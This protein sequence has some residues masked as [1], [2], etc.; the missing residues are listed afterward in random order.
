MWACSNIF[1][2]DFLLCLHSVG[3]RW[4]CC[5]Q[6]QHR[7]LWGCCRERGNDYRYRQK[8]TVIM[9]RDKRISQSAQDLSGR[10]TFQCRPNLV[11]LCIK[12]RWRIMRTSNGKHESGRKS[13]HGK[14]HCLLQLLAVILWIGAAKF[15]HCL[16]ILCV[17]L[18]SFL[19]YKGTTCGVHL[20]EVYLDLQ[21]HW[22]MSFTD[23]SLAVFYLLLCSQRIRHRSFLSAAQQITAHWKDISFN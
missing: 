13:K 4:L 3:L 15:C 18:F 14:R 23:F 11:S 16:L 19:F 5:A 12:T 10:V 9:I 20:L 8:N 17:D 1:S 6:R 2:I 21:E 7:R 22:R